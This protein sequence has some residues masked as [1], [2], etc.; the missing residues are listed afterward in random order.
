M[1]EPAIKLL[2]QAQIDWQLAHGRERLWARTHNKIRSAIPHF[3]NCKG[4]GYKLSAS[5]GLLGSFGWTS[6]TYDR[7]VITKACFPGISQKSLHSKH[8]LFLPIVSDV[9]N[10]IQITVFGQLEPF[11]LED[12]Q[13]QRI[14][15]RRASQEQFTYHYSWKHNKYI[16]EQNLRNTVRS[17]LTDTSAR[18]TPRWNGQLELTP[19]CLSSLFLVASLWHWHLRPTHGCQRNSSLWWIK[20]RFIKGKIN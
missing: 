13:V 19:S 10:L 14:L 7:P 12:G 8:A 17:L 1:D 16:R 9:G 2:I 6:V 11:P 18:R 5:Q 15:V 4:K 20:G 3:R